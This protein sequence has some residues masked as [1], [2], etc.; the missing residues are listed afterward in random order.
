MEGQQMFKYLINE[1]SFLD[2]KSIL[3]D[4]PTRAKCYDIPKEYPCI[5]FTQI[6]W[7]TYGA[8]WID[9]FFLSMEDLNEEIKKSVS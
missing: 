4:N 7:N 8:D 1:Q 6:M 5:C 2:W 9:L 3:E